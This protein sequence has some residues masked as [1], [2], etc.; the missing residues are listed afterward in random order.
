MIVMISIHN[1]QFP[2]WIVQETPCFIPSDY[3]AKELSLSAIFM[4]SPEMLI[5]VSFCSLV[6]T[7]DTKMWPNAAHV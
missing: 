3:V 1:M 6:N 4:S 7:R 5:L 2:L